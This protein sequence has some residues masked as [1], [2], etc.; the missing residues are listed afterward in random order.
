MFC[1]E[2]IRI[3]FSVRGRREE[4]MGPVPIWTVN[5]RKCLNLLTIKKVIGI[6]RYYKEYFNKKNEINIGKNKLLN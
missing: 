6:A 5:T 1:Y 4:G 2:K 3:R